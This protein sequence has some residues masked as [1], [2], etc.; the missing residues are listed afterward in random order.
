MKRAIFLVLTVV[1]L[2]GLT[3]CVGHGRRAWKCGGESVEATDCPNNASVGNYDPEQ[4]GPCRACGGRGCKLC[5]DRCRAGNAPADTGPA[6]AAI[7]Y[8]YYTTRGPRDFL[9]K[10]PQSIG[11]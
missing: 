8:P 11:P 4:V 3:G 5:R 9:A 6:S 10:N 7:T 2:V 1:V